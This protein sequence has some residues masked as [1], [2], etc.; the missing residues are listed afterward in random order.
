MI[1]ATRLTKQY[2]S[3]NALFD[4]NFSIEEGE[5]VGFLEPNGAGKSTLINLLCAMRRMRPCSFSKV[6][7]SILAIC[8]HVTFRS[9]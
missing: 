3:A 5:V 9:G 8:A 7:V 1:E 2:G 6:S 4:V